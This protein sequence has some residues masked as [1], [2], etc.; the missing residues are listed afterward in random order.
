MQWG[1][2]LMISFTD[3]IS[4]FSLMAAVISFIPAFLLCHCDIVRETGA[5]EGDE[6]DRREV[7]KG[8]SHDSLSI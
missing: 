2:G 3:I 6:T 1:G 5:R 7:K 8:G 4:Y